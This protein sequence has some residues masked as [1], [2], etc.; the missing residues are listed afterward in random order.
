V[1]ESMRHVV[2]TRLV[3]SLCM[4]FVVASFGFAVAARRLAGAPAAAAP[5]ANGA[6]LFAA[7]CGAC[8]AAS[9][10]TA[11]GGGTL[12]ARARELT[13]F[14]A[15]HGDAP[16]EADRSIVAWLLAQPSPPSATPP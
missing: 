10:L 14:L 8:H 15:D 7:H 5:P 6:A 16:A 11:P 12:E 9:D 3:L 4:L 2:V 13:A 1:T